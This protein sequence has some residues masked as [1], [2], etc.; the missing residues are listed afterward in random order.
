MK[1]KLITSLDMDIFVRI[2]YLT[3]QEKCE[4]TEFFNPNFVN[5][6]IKLSAELR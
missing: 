4:G 6:Y 3:R 5:F 1:A 2:E